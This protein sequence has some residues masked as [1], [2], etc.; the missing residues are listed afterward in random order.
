[1]T[2]L[3]VRV[4][5]KS[6]T[7]ILLLH[8]RRVVDMAEGSPGAVHRSS[9]LMY[10]CGKAIHVSRSEDK[11]FKKSGTPP[12]GYRRNVVEVQQHTTFNSASIQVVG[13][14]GAA[15]EIFQIIRSDF[16]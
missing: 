14:P 13:L 11:A 10:L 2:R 9:D 12:G 1:M 3:C 4:G 7:L 6:S 8:A 5:G 15:K 16:A